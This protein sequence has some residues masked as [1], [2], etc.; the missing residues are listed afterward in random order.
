MQTRPMSQNQH[1]I[2]EE[3][4]LDIPYGEVRRQLHMK[5]D[6]RWEA[7]KSIVQ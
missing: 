4:P 3:I 6:D 5:K 1:H 7:A 2:L